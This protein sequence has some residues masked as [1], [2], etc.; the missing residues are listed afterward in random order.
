MSGIIPIETI[1][2]REEIEMRFCFSFFFFHLRR[3]MLDVCGEN[4]VANTRTSIDSRSGAR[5][6]DNARPGRDI[7]SPFLPFGRLETGTR[8]GGNLQTEKGPGGRGGGV[9][10]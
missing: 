3:L 7:F 8:R 5:R 2:L 6:R 10:V 9:C 4:V 1:R